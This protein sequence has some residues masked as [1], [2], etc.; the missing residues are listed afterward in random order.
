PRLEASDLIDSVFAIRQALSAPICAKPTTSFLFLPP[1]LEVLPVV[2]CDEDDLP[3][4]SPQ[5]ASGSRKT[6]QVSIEIRVSM[7]C[8]LRLVAGLAIVR[9]SAMLAKEVLV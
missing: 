8:L 2:G 6:T 9:V 3:L 5:P 1:P 7:A 4:S